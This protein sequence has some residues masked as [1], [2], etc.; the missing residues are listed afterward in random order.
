MAEALRDMA[1]DEGKKSA[2]RD[3][4]S[5]FEIQKKI[6][7]AYRNGD[8][9]LLDSLHNLTSVSASFS[10]KFLYLRN[11]IQANSIDTILKSKACL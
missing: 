10:E 6:Q 5:Y 7:Q 3:Y 11:E 9:D 2:D 4:E 1:K 8:L